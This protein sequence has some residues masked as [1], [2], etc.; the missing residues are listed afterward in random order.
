M[1]ITI[2]D[3]GFCKLPPLVDYITEKELFTIL[4]IVPDCTNIEISAPSFTRVRESWNKI[5]LE[6][7]KNNGNGMD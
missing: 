2:N 3:C 6:G 1:L 7:G 4:C 5:N